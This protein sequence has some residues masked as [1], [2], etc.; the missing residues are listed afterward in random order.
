MSTPSF[1]I[2]EYSSAEKEDEIIDFKIKNVSLSVSASYRQPSCFR[3][4]KSDTK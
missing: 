2:E 1:F 3:S 4:W